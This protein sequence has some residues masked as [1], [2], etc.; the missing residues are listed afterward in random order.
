MTDPLSWIALGAAVGGA[1][2]KF[3]EIAWESGEKWIQSYFANH[4]VEA[5]EK[6]KENTLSFLS[7]LAKRVENLEK[8]QIVSPEL[9][10]SAQKHPEFSVI[11]QRAILSA[12]QTEI[13][14]KHQL[15]A[16][17]V[18]ERIKAKPESL[19]ALASKMAVDAIAFATPKQLKILGLATV[20]GHLTPNQNLSNNQYEL[21]LKTRLS[22]FKGTQVSSLDYLHLESL[23]CL[24]FE[25]FI[26][27]DLS[28]LL[29]GK[30][31]EPFDYEVFKKTDIGVYSTDVWE[32]QQLKSVTM[33]SVGIMIGIMV[34]DKLSNSRTNFQG[35]E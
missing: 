17:L 22:V 29:S 4:H 18:S 1:A 32:R 35:W 13:K 27:R 2:G 11:L 28:E 23:S 9:I 6:A 20:L 26:T 8:D 34:S 25:S 19:F 30:T 21:W 24:K 12:G 33:T 16:R 7:D 15:L 10:S 31:K 3:V 14:D 5:K